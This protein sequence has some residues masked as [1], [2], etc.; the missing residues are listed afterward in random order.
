PTQRASAGASRWLVLCALGFGSL[1]RLLTGP[2]PAHDRGFERELLKPDPEIEQHPA[3][4]EDEYGRVPPETLRRL[5][6]CLH[7]GHACVSSKS[8]LSVLQLLPGLLVVEHDEL[9]KGRTA[10]LH[11]D[12]EL[13]ESR[14]A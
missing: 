6:T 7:E 11:A 5:R 8:V 14:V 10:E 13:D 9:V 3:L 4:V 2:E 1:L 12:G